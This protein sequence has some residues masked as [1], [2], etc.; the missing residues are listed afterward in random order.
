MFY[1][2]LLY[3]EMLLPQNFRFQLFI[4]L[5]VYFK[6]TCIY[7]NVDGSIAPFI[8]LGPLG[9]TFALYI[10][11]IIYWSASIAFPLM[12]TYFHNMLYRSC[13]PKV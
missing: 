8:I 7:N 5:S 12:L 10:V 13:G 9:E 1:I 4:Y 6:H 3:D 11:H 2:Y